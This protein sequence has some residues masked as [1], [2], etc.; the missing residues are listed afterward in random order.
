[1]LTYNLEPAVELTGKSL[2][3]YVL[4]RFEIEQAGRLIESEKWRSGKARSLFKVLLSRR[5]YQISRQ[6]ISELLW[7]ELDQE[8]VSNNLNQAVYSLRRTLEPSLERAS[9]SSYLK[10][11]GSKIQLNPALIGWIDL[12]EFKR[13]RRQAQLNGD[14]KLYEQAANLYCGDY[15][16]EDLYEE[17]SFYQREALREE[18][19]A[20]LV[21]MSVLYQRQGQDDKYQQCLH[22]V[23]ECNF[24]HD[25]AVQSLMLALV[26]NNRRD[27]ALALYHNFASKLRAR[28]NI[29]PLPETWQ[30]YRDIA[31]GRITAHASQIKLASL[32]APLVQTAAASRLAEAGPL[33]DAPEAPAGSSMPLELREALSASLSGLNNADIPSAKAPPSEIGPAQPEI[34]LKNPR[35][36]PAPAE[37]QKMVGRR[38]ELWRW[39][40][41]LH[42]A[43]AGQ[44]SLTLLAGEAGAGKSCLARALGQAATR[45]GFEVLYVT[46]YPQQ[47]ELPFSPFCQLL[48]QALSRLNKTE[49]EEWLKYCDPRLGRLIPAVAHLAAA[50]P[51]QVEFTH[52]SLFAAIVQAFAWLGQHRPLTLVLDD[53]H[54]LP[55]PSLALLRY[56]LTHPHRPSLLVLGTLR[57]VVTAS[58]PHPELAYLLDWAAENGQAIHRLERLSLEGISEMLAER[59]E[60][61]PGPGL[62]E[63][64][65]R[66]SWGNPRLALELALAWRKEGY[67]KLE[68]TC[69]EVG[70]SWNDALP[71]PVAAFLKRLVSGLS[72]ETQRLL[73]LAALVGQNFSFDILH[74][75]LHRRADGAGWSIELDKNQ[76]GQLLTELIGRE[77]IHEQGTGY[78]FAYPLL[79]EFLVANLPYSQRQRWREVVVWTQQRI[80]NNFS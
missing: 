76:L 6:E 12:E 42:Q 4:G 78:C 1:M 74:E 61:P 80:S 5:G 48:E 75:I 77:L 69:W 29:E 15:L 23:L 31:A 59:L 22:R 71:P 19:V 11:E 47:V 73:A 41:T 57:P 43:Q 13:L 26:E 53:L 55:G 39:Q 38:E 52:Q 20:L 34:L 79:A 10:T 2:R 46:C 68:G 17:W 18:W 9:N 28:L 40:Q 7:P 54:Y 14:L 16:P 60:Y 62:L 3:I 65:N 56:L 21:E 44:T 72:Q 37:P 45:A 24:S 30:L 58:H 64:V 70:E 50:E 63:L 36:F 35:F 49:L 8:R 25:G 51:P 33:L 32:Q 67:L 66:L 27:E